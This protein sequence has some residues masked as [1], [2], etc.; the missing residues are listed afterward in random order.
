[1]SEKTEGPIQNGQSRGT[2]NIG[3]TSHRTKTKKRQNKDEQHRLH[4]K[5]PGTLVIVS[6]EQFSDDTHHLTNIAKY[7]DDIKFK[8]K[9]KYLQYQ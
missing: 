8:I 3:Q 6:D 9:S 2:N 1:M 7:F 4:S 5:H